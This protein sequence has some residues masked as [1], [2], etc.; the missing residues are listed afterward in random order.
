MTVCDLRPSPLS[1]AQ[2]RLPANAWIAVE[3]R[4]RQLVDGVIDALA[5]CA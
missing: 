4:S 5:S 3:A 2:D 1:G